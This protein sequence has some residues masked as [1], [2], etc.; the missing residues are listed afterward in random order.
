MTSYNETNE[1]SDY[2]TE[3]QGFK[4]HLERIIFS[5]LFLHTSSIFFNE[6]KVL[7][8]SKDFKGET[9]ACKNRAHFIYDYN[10]TQSHDVLIDGATKRV[11]IWHSGCMKRSRFAQAITATT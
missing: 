1:A 2:C 6:T 8:H 4:S 11:F 7:S 3:S 5:E 10:Q 9:F